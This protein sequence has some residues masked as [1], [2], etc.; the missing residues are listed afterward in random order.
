MA[1]A[2]AEPGPGGERAVRVTVI[3]G[4]GGAGKTTLAVHVAH[5]LAPRFP[6]GQ[7]FARLRTGDRPVDPADVLERFLRVLGVSG[8]GLPVGVEERAELF[9]DLLGGRRMLI[10]L[11]DAMTEQQVEALLPGTAQCSVLVTSRRRLTGLPAAGRIEISALARHSSVQL[12]SRVAGAERIGAEPAS[13]ADL[14]RLCGDLPLALRIGA[15]RLAARPHWSVADLVERL[16]DES[17]RLDEL[18]H[19]GMQ[20]RASIRLSYDCL[21]EDARLLLRRLALLEA[22]HFAWWVGAALLQIAPL[23]AQDALEALAEAYLV[24]T[25]PG[26]AAGQVRYRFHDIMR[27]FAS[28]QL[29]QDPADE[30]RA[31]LERWLDALLMVAEE[32]RRREYGG[33]QPE[34]QEHSAS[35]SD[36]RA[37]A[38]Q[39]PL[40]PALVDRLLENPTAWY[41][42]EHSS[43]VAAVRQ[44]AA[45]G[46]AA[47]CWQLALSA[48]PL[49]ESRA[50]FSDWRETHALALEAAC[51]AGDRRGEAAMRYSLG[52]LHMLERKS[53]AAA[54]QFEPAYELYQQLADRRGMA[55]V[56]RELGRLDRARGNLKS[57]RVRAREALEAFQEQGDRIAEAQA[58]QDLALIHLDHDEPDAAEALLNQATD[59]SA[60]SGNRALAGHIRLQQGE[61][62]LSRGELDRAAESFIAVLDEARGRADRV[63]ECHALL[64]V[65]TVDLRRGALA[66][67]VRSLATARALAVATGDRTAAG[68]IALT[69]AEVA[70]Q[71]TDLPAAAE[72]ASQAVRAFNQ[73]GAALLQAQALTMRGR[74]DLAADNHGAAVAALKSARAILAGLDLDGWIPLSAQLTNLLD[75]SDD[76]GLEGK[77]KA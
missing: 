6:D 12:L 41:D 76:A 62:L 55:L 63:G 4:R 2:G 3:V 22:P 10:V 66:R 25:E 46:F 18:D 37:A 47:Q 24:D 26:P 5:L 27:L 58:L 17:R 70:L 7:L 75:V 40:P 8:A 53:E 74:I 29:A 13:V 39:P 52:A 14:C 33:G 35:Q 42:Q 31:A 71:S 68:R 69:L 72:H 32:A 45:A 20:M 11:D 77:G 38:T 43:L 51:Q 61:L 15:A 19:G 60:Q 56:L 1:E 28:E 54:S 57:A 50:Y 64:G 34:Q 23:R 44:A 73:V 49:F 48:V 21:P 36:P 65:G 30:R 9:R 16:V 59:L 67:S